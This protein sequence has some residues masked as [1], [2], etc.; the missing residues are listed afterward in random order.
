MNA[1]LST[2]SIPTDVSFTTSKSDLSKLQHHYETTEYPKGQVLFQEGH[3]AWGL[4]YIYQG[5]IKLHKYGSDGKEQIIRIA[6]SGD[7]LGYTAVL[8]DSHYHVSATVLEEATVAFIPRQDFLNAFGHSPDVS[9]HFTQLL[10]RDLVDTEQ[11]LV[12]QSYQP[13]RGRLADMLLSLDDF[14]EQGDEKDSFINLSRHDLASLLG[15]A[16]ETVIRLLSEFKAEN[17]IATNG[18][19][20]AIL[21]R[22]ELK[23]ISQMYS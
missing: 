5:K 20:I 16:K 10:C 23:N 13:V 4:Y 7:F 12:A 2:L 19:F 9:Q 18:Q 8:N 3:T 14:Y 22:R 1:L 21:N 6:G 17:L 11:R 15:S